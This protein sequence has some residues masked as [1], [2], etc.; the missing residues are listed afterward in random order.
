MTVMSKKFKN[1]KINKDEFRKYLEAF[2]LNLYEYQIEFLY[3]I[4]IYEYYNTNIIV[5]KY[6]K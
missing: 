4:Y 1:R 3:N 6:K 2:G 5:N